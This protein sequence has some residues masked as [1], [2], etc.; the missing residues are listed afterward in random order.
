M[1]EL[2]FSVTSSNSS[3]PFFAASYVWNSRSKRF[4]AALIHNMDPAN[5]RRYE[6]WYQFRDP[7]THQLRAK[8]RAAFV[9]EV[10]PYPVLRWTE[11]YND[12]LKPDGL[13]HGINIF[14]FDGDRDL[15]D[16]R[17]WREARSP[18]FYDRETSL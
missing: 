3:G 7:H 18:D 13:H 9:E 16:F 5:I 11:F 14:L 6:T 1:F 8:R 15:G 17:L 2:P 10:T 4:D 12:F